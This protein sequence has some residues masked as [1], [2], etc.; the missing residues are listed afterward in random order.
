MKKTSVIITL[1]FISFWD[2][3]QS[4]S[5]NHW[6][7]VIFN[8][9][10]WRYFVGISEPDSNWRSLSFNDEVWAQGP[11]GI[12]YSD[13]DDNTIIQSCPSV[14]IRHKFNVIDT[15]AI[16]GALLNMDYDDAFIAYLND[17]EIAR[18]GITGVHPAYN[19][20]GTDHEAAMYQGGLP[21][22]FYI[23][24]SKLKT[25]LIPGENVLAI[26]VHNSSL[27][28]SDMSS[29]AF[30]S[31][32]I[33]NTSNNYRNVPSWFQAPGE[34]T[35]SNLPIVI[36][37]TNHGE[38]IKDSPRITAD[39]KIIYHAGGIRNYVSDSGNVYT[40]KISIEIRGTY[41]AS[42]PQKPYG[43]ETRDSLGVNKN[44]SLL[45]MPP[46]NDWVLLANY[47]DKTFLRNVLAFDI[48]HKMANYSTRMRYC[49]VVINNEYQ[50][51]YLLGEKIKQ[52]K[53]RV[54][55]AKLKAEDNSGDD[56]T[57][58]YII[59]IDYYTATNSWM[60]RF[61]PLNKPGEKVYFVYSD[62]EPED[63]TDKQKTYIQ[64]FINSMETV[65]YNPSFKSPV[66]G[67]KAY[68]DIKSFADYF[69]LGEVTRNVDTYKK[70][71]YLYKNKD[72]KDGLL[73]SGPPWDFDWAWKNLLENCINFNKTDGSGWA[74][75]INDC[76]AYP[77]PPSWEVRMLQDSEFANM[78]HD[79]YFEL[80]N[81]ILSQT[82]IERTIDSVAGLIDEAQNRH[83]QKWN[84]LG[85]N[86]GTPEPDFQP[87][88]Y[89]GE[90]VKF[91]T[92]INLRLAWL[93]ANMISTISSVED[94]SDNKLKCRVFPN[95]ASDILYIES[96]KE[97]KNYSIYNITGILVKEQSGL[98]DFS[99]TAVVSSLN[100]GMYILRIIFSNEEIVTTR[101]LK[102]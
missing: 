14:F 73:H 54:N 6:E 83:F 46:E 69:I 89:Y 11:G 34:F 98:C 32:G 68:I 17:F 5:I 3:V 88:S 80:R 71:R 28:S 87:I 7:T 31:F 82:Q 97:I 86:V 43:F 65:L 33:T 78:V 10:S 37:S 4:Q 57:G 38:T 100:S 94:R 36:I 93:D 96:D 76:Y 21:E 50:G 91:K 92:W 67:Y 61:S 29:N 40:G 64:E 30:L 1:I 77:V 25:V 24:K 52:D 55:I 27:T 62:P 58:G 102:K 35:S 101:V 42:L 70:S 41:S 72:S 60:S 47:N 53:G 90:I 49:E 79:R 44:V 15:A 9:D 85:I 39:L 26:Q 51:I 66:F 74:Y 48:F 56:V 22:S 8:N 45:G 84:I 16:A 18:S 23:E 75:K 20:L 59:K 2:L 95:P 99:V 81:T 19:Q 63:L 12:G 13:N